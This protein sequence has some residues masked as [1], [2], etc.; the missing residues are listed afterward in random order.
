MLGRIPIRIDNQSSM[1]MGFVNH[2][3]ISMLSTSICKASQPTWKIE[4]VF[5]HGNRADT[6]RTD[7]SWDDH[8]TG[9]LERSDW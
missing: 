3:Y 8:S 9:C 1:S 4:V 5:F 6:V 2:R 7:I